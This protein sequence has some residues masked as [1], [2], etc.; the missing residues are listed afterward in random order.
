MPLPKPYP[1]EA[2]KLLREMGAITK[3]QDIKEYYALN[4]RLRAKWWES[5]ILFVLFVGGL[6]FVFTV[7]YL[8]PARNAE[9]F[10]RFLT[11]WATLLIL[12]LI[13]TIEFLISKIRALRRLY[14]IHTRLIEE[15]QNEVEKRTRKA[16]ENADAKK[17][18]TA[19]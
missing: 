14:E 3:I 15:L 16:P 4:E 1:R 2:D 12:A 18:N 5:A 6:G 13:A 10:F 7:F 17:S 11:F 9:I 8:V 19:D